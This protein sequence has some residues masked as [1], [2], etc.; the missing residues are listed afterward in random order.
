[1]DKRDMNKTIA[2]I[3][4]GQLGSRHLQGLA[5]IAQALDIY[6][7]DPSPDSIRVAIERF[8]AVATPN[9]STVTSL[10]E[11][12]ALPTK[13]DV[14][15]VATAAHVRFDVL[16][17]LLQHARVAKLL[18]EKVLFQDLA[19]YEAAAKLLGPLGASTWVNCAQRLW[20]FFIDL[21][22]Q[23]HNDAHLE[24]VISGSNWGLGCNAVHNTDIAAFLWDGAQTQVPKLDARVA[25]SKRAG[26]KEFTGELITEVAGGGRLR[27][28]S[29]ATGEAPFMITVLHPAVHQTWNVVTGQLYSANAANGWVPQASPLA[30]PFQS[31]L[32]ASIVGAMLDGTDCG[33]PTFAQAAATHVAT[34]QALLDGAKAN[35][36]DFGACC[37]VT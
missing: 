32:T 26:F 5:K 9:G 11:I 17:R 12:E 33:L 29:Y 20:P 28:I 24:L 19:Q 23:F 6:I 35:G 13:L 16:T 1:M 18:L 25:D 7:V 22:R 10:S 8:D 15:I 2:V 3:G 14:V 27:Q 4:A 37:P 30:A 21:R 36:A 34:L 31:Q